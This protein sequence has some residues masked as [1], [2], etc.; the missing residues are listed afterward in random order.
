VAT[1]LPLVSAKPGIAPAPTK[2]PGGVGDRT[3][4]Q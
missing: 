4:E 2:Q 1:E 3:E